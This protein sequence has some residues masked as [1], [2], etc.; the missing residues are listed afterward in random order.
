VKART[1]VTTQVSVDS[2]RCQG[3]GRCAL[4]A[5]QIFDLD[6]EGSAIVISGVEAEA[7]LADV[8]EAVR[9]CPERAIVLAE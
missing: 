5:P 8:R 2:E 4:I 1:V 9:S 3:H 7:A 6:D